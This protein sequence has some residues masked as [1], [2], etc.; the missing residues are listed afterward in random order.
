MFLGNKKAPLLGGLGH[1]RQTP[2]RLQNYYYDCAIGGLVCHLYQ[3]VSAEA[4]LQ[5]RGVDNF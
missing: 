5:L 2:V 1:T 4:H 3:C